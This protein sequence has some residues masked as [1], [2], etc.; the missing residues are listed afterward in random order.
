[1]SGEEM[2]IGEKLYFLRTKQTWTLAQVS[3][4]TRVSMSHLSAI[5]NGTR[6]NPSFHTMSRIAKAFNVP[7]SYFEDND[8]DEIQFHIDDT[9]F[10]ETYVEK[11]QVAYEHLDEDTRNFIVSESAP[12]YLTLARHLSQRGVLDD[13]AALLAWIAE[14]LR[15][16]ESPYAKGHGKK[17]T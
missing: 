16:E 3:T 9:A 8:E 12:R 2:S 5:E 10:P 4:L 14:Y 7:L 17:R 13:T 6:P 1:M 15:S 11:S